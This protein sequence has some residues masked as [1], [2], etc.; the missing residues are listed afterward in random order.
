MRLVM[1]SFLDGKTGFYSTPFFMAHVGQA[2]RAAIDLAEDTST[3]IARHPADFSL[4]QLGEWDDQSGQYQPLGNP[5][6]IGTVLSLMP[7]K[8]QVQPLFDAAPDGV[9][10]LMHP[11]PNGR[12]VL[13]A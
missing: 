9:E 6:V 10:R 12:D 2:V 5:T 7:P 4:V 11:R 3:T 1:F 8:R 13:E